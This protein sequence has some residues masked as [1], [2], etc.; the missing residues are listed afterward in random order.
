[1]A[2]QTKVVAELSSSDR[3]GIAR[4]VAEAIAEIG[5]SG[6]VITQ[7]CAVAKKA[8][9]GHA[10][11][12]D[13]I[14]SITADVAKSPALQALNKRNR[15]NTLSRWRTVLAVYSQVPEATES[16]RAKLGRC[17]NQLMSLRT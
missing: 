9:G 16:L 17:S 2:N 5:K 15:D 8:A 10:L 7:V 12:Q 11:S 3:S 6:S 1:M 4:S 14:D 13:D